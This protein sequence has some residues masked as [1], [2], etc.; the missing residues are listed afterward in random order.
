[1]GLIAAF[2]AFGE[3]AGKPIPQAAAMLLRMVRSEGDYHF[4]KLKLQP[5]RVSPGTP[6]N[7]S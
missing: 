5:A 6:V 1:M 3:K 2:A 4:S 7:D